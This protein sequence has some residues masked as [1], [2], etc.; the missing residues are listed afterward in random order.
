MVCSAILLSLVP[1]LG[2]SDSEDTVQLEVYSWWN[3]EAERVAFDAVVNIHRAK[4]ESVAIKNL[5][6][7]DSGNSRAE[8]AQRMLAEVPPATFQANVGADV[9]QW[10][11]FDTTSDPRA[12]VDAGPDG[13]GA[14]I[15]SFDDPTGEELTGNLPPEV[16]A[17]LYVGRGR[18]GPFAVPINIHRLN[19]LYY[20]K[21]KLDEVGGPD[22][23]TLDKLCPS[24]PETAAFPAK[25][26]VAPA[27][28]WTLV[29]LVFENIF[30]A[31]GG[32]E[33]YEQV[34][35]GE[36]PP[37]A[38]EKIREA[39][40]CARYLSRS[41]VGMKPPSDVS[42]EAASND[43]WA[44]AVTAVKDGDAT[45]TVMGDW[46]N[47]LLKNE[48]RTGEVVATPFPGTADYFVFT[49]DSFPLPVG[50][51]HPRE[52]L[53]FLRTIASP[54][55]QIAFSELKGSIPA[56]TDVDF[57]SPPGWAT[58]HEFEQKRKVLATS[59]FFPPYYPDLGASLDGTL[60]SE[61]ISDDDLERT[62]RE[63]L[64]TVP[65]LRRWQDRLES[66]AEPP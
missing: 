33:L 12:N 23:L 14:L 6:N 29:L 46:A 47:G 20:N 51:E 58:H 57:T 30:L 34:F 19:V 55:A 38:E 13:G 7:P 50:V 3:Q 24:D 17:Q 41:F 65:L 26:A 21:A 63:F 2:C 42:T 39:L 8:L 59:G 62:L 11:V 43:R 9:L 52:A 18:T 45:F 44:S 28:S 54:A 15:S 49:S 36:L 35:R 4:H 66:G 60:L 32:P 10:A 27:D 61:D 56:R 53:D 31:L 48:L 5:V 37:G 1:T 40:A 64:D 22:L 16:K 25:Y